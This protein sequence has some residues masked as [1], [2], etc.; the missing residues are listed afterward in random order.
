MERP[1]G[2]LTVGG[3][4]VIGLRVSMDADGRIYVRIVDER[5][6]VHLCVFDSWQQALVSLPRWTHDRDMAD[7][8]AR[9]V[10]KMVA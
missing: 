3:L 2:K 8:I 6:T 10:R 4:R 1:K 9:S 7:V 5:E